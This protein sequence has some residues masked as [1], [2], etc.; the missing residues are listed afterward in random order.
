MNSF[1]FLIG[2]GLL[3]LLSVFIAYRMGQAGER[4]KYEKQKADCVSA[5]KRAREALCDPAAVGRLHAKYK[6]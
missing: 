5:A 2:Q 1:Y 4:E 6:R 3:T